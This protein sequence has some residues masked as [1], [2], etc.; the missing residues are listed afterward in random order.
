MRIASQYDTSRGEATALCT[1]GPYS[2]RQKLNL[3]IAILVIILISFM[4]LFIFVDDE[5]GMPWEWESSELVELVRA[6]ALKTGFTIEML[7]FILVA[8]FASWLG[9]RAMDQRLEIGR[10]GIRFSTHLPGFAKRFHPDWYIP[11][12]EFNEVRYG[13]HHP[14]AKGVPLTL[15]FKSNKGEHKVDVRLPWRPE[16]EKFSRSAK[17]GFYLS[18]RERLRESFSDNALVKA[19]GEHGVEIESGSEAPIEDTLRKSKS[20]ISIAVVTIGA[21]VYGI[22]EL[23]VLH[24]TWFSPP[25]Y[26]LAALAFIVGM[27][28]WVISKRLKLNTSE[29]SVVPVLLGAAFAFAAYPGMLRVNILLDEEGLMEA[30]YRLQADHTLVPIALATPP[31]DISRYDAIWR[32]MEVDAVYRVHVRKGGLGFYQFDIAE[33]RAITR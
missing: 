13:R 4:Q 33:L 3:L 5:L 7:V 26:E 16:G 10:S 31:I 9:M 29:K 21:F 25:W 6:A 8:P 2:R 32:D 1:T 22:Y 20:G 30:D 11:W 28:G 12:S 23:A 17:R 27:T 24:E 19:L 18:E 15:V 14:M